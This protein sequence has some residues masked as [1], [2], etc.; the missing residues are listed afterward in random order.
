MQDSLSA[1][2][3]KTTAETQRARRKTQLIHRKGAEDAKEN[4]YK[5]SRQ[6]P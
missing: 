3:H 4:N 6:K 5:K 1:K 2:H